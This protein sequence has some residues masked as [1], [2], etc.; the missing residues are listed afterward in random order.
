MHRD[1]KEEA[2]V[3]AV[4]SLSG[5]GGKSVLLLI[6]SDGRYAVDRFTE[7]GVNRR[8]VGRFQPFQLSGCWSVEFLK[9]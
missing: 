2:F 4:H 1:E 9:Y 5:L 6:S 3:V 8:L 7:V